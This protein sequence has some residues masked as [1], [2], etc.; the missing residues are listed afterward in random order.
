MATD[1][2]LSPFGKWLLQQGYTDTS[3]PTLVKRLGCSDQSIRNYAAGRTPPRI[4]M[5]KKLVR[6]TGL[7][8]TDFYDPFGEVGR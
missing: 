3:Y 2:R 1:K 6:L 4:G 5:A 7:R 8:L